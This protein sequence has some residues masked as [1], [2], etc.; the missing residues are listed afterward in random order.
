[1]QVKVREV[2]FRI[3]PSITFSFRPGTDITALLGVR[4]HIAGGDEVGLFVEQFP[5]AVD[6]LP[7]AA[8]IIHMLFHG[9]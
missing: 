6:E 7:G 4:G 3:R 5:T 2:A 9:C 8:R 1:M